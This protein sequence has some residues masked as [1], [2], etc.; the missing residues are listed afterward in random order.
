MEIKKIPDFRPDAYE[1]SELVPERVEKK[2][3]YLEDLKSQLEVF[4]REKESLEQEIAKLQDMIT[5][6]EKVDTPKVE[7][8]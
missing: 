1:I 2:V 8:I 5:Q 3:V 7:M 6:L 4:L